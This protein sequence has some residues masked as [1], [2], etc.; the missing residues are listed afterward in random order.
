MIKPFIAFFILLT[1]H[2]SMAQIA[3]PSE[4]MLD[5]DLS[6]AHSE[7]TEE[8]EERGIASDKSSDNEELKKQDKKKVEYWSY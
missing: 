4:E 6:F 3:Q 5:Q 2:I 8:V 1:C 7:E